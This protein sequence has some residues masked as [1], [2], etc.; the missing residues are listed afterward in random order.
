[1]TAA[2][3]R[4]ARKAELADKAA[5]QREI[6]LD[7]IDALEVEH[8]DSNIAVLTVPFTPGLPVMVAARCPK[9]AE[10]KRYQTR[11]RTKK[12]GS[13]GDPIA[14]AEEIAACCR[15]YPDGDSYDALCTARAGLNVQL[16]VA[17]ITLSAA[18]DEAEGKG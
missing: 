11:V 16:G 5:E 12:D 17:A 2:E 7:A 4:A 14:A 10:I 6:D 9:P 18:K 13:A 8:G 15:V 3:R 1:M